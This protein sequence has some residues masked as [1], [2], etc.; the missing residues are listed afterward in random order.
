M[1]RIGVDIV[2]NERI[3]KNLSDSFLRHILSDEEMEEYRCRNDK[4]EYVA[5][6]FA[7]KEAIIKCLIKQMITDLAAISITDGP[8]GEPVAS[9]GDYDI[10]V[11]ISH[12][13]EYTVAMAIVVMPE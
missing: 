13:T 7:A 5:G 12:E 1:Y 8:Y 9:F 10:Q 4:T 11:S 3:A 6:R 2:K